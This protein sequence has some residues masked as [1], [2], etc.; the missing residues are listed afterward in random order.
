M[1]ISNQTDF[2]NSH[3]FSY[4]NTY[5]HTSKLQD[6]K[7]QTKWS[8]PLV[9]N[10]EDKGGS[11]HPPHW[12][13]AQLVIA[14]RPLN[15]FFCTILGIRVITVYVLPENLFIASYINLRQSLHWPS[16]KN[17]VKEPCA[18]TLLSSYYNQSQQRPSANLCAV[19]LCLPV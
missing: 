14:N 11:S 19:P 6:F 4:R 5:S 13:S 1:F 3:S 17:K 12:G 8:L 16:R 10:T 18:E 9:H 15:N 7:H 2:S